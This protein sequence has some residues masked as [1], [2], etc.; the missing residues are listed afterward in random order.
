MAAAPAMDVLLQVSRNPDCEAKERAVELVDGG[1]NA[2]AVTTLRATIAELRQKGLDEQFE[3][4]EEVGSWKHFVERIERRQFDTTSRKEMRDQS[5]Q[6]QA[7]GRAESGATGSWRR[8]G[9]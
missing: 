3:I 8:L 1:D 9:A 6:A 2:G 4:A 7:A 5:Y